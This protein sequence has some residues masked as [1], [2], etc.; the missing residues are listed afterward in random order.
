M[1]ASTASNVM[2]D[3]YAARILVWSIELPRTASEM[4]E[5]LGIPISACYNR[6]RMLEDFGLLKCVEMRVSPSGKRIAVYQSLLRKASIFLE[7]GEVRVKMELADGKVEDMT[8][9]KERD[10]ISHR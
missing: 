7:R 6:I 5:S 8:L 3:E 10:A 1:D 2:N 9:V 4:S